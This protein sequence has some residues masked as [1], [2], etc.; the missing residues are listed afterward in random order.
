MQRKSIFFKTTLNSLFNERYDQ[1]VTDSLI[2]YFDILEKW[3]F[4]NAIPSMQDKTLVIQNIENSIEPIVIV[5]MILHDPQLEKLMFQRHLN[6]NLP[7]AINVVN[8]Q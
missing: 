8:R 4:L 1:F 2:S 6:I 3:T 5:E 7:Q